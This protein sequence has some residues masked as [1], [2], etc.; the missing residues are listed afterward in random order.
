MKKIVSILTS[1]IL[2]T[3]VFAFEWGGIIGETSYVDNTISTLSFN[4]YADIDLW[5]RAQ[6]N[7]NL[8]L[9]G[10]AFYSL[11]YDFSQ[12]SFASAA[13]QKADLNSFFLR[14]IYALGD[15][16]WS[17][18]FSVGRFIVADTTSYI[19]SQKLDGAGVSFTSPK[20]YVLKFYAGYTGLLNSLTNSVYS[21]YYSQSDSI[22][23]TFAVPYILADFTASFQ[24]LFAGQNLTIEALGAIDANFGKT[25]Y[26]RAYISLALDGPIYKSL[27]YALASSFEGILDNTEG[28]TSPFEFANLSKAEIMYFFDWNSLVL[29]A[30]AIYVTDKFTTITET[31]ATI[32]S[33]AYNAMFK[34]GVSTAAKF[35]D[36][37]K[38]SLGLDAI[39]DSDFAY[40]GLQYNI[41]FIYQILDDL[42]LN[43]Y[44]AQF[45]YNNTPIS[46]SYLTAK[47][48]IRIAF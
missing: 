13:I 46:D 6:F 5:M 43:I 38:L 1:L 27:Y 15:S 24:S 17:T 45:F 39:F 26:N 33:M 35:I 44:A 23:Y 10:D 12:D 21:P 4:E 34:T 22:I 16:N 37:I 3:S 9:S 20:S 2:A 29:S 48:S 31:D 41:S 14:G 18:A 19:L 8:S 7:K 42:Q 40:T 36:V 25:A 30:N 47:G 11:D 28:S 32:D